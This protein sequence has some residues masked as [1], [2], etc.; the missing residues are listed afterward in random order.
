MSDIVTI[1]EAGYVQVAYTYTDDTGTHPVYE[2]EDWGIWGRQFQENLFGAFIEQVVTRAGNTFFYH[3]PTTELRGTA[4]RSNPVSGNAVWLGGVRAFDTSHSGYLPVSGSARL[5]VDFSD[6]TI[7]VD[8]TDFD[9]DHDDISWEALQITGGS[10]R[11][12]HDRQYLPTIEGAFYGAEHQGVAGEF[13][14]DNLSG[15][16]GAVR[17]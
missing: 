6:A 1:D 13:N 12:F 8:F 17:N 11:A 15:V 9:T 7:D 16:F 10:F 14:R 5:E 4:S 3:T 2:Y